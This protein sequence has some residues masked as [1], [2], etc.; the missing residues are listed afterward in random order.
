MT[1]IEYH[2]INITLYIILIFLA[3]SCSTCPL[4]PLES[5][6]KRWLSQHIAV[7]IT[8]CIRVPSQRPVNSMLI[9]QHTQLINSFPSRAVES[10]SQPTFNHAAAFLIVGWRVDGG[11][12]GG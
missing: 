5:D 12:M 4:L 6:Q 11:R 3:H 10:R 2:R 9:I 7:R 1:E 8:T